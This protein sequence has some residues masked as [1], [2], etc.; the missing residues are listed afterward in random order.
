MRK[1]RLILVAVLV[2]DI[3]VALVASAKGLL[4]SMV[5]RR[6]LTNDQIDHILARHPEAELRL[7]AQDWRGMTYQLHRFANMTNYVELIG[8]SNDCARV[9]LQLHDRGETLASS[10]AVLAKAV[11]GWKS[12]ADEWQATAD[13]WRAFGIDATNR[14]AATVADY[15]SASNRA[16][17]AE[18]RTSALV[19]WA[20]EQRDKALLPS[21]KAIW[22]SF[23]DRI[24]QEY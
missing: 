21:T 17:R 18:A 13:E 16:T 23:I 24:R 6:G 14:L 11:A 1:S 3:C 22:Q 7:T 15:M 19:T 10:N 5:Y 8:N 2:A 9:L 4:P 12:A 20:E